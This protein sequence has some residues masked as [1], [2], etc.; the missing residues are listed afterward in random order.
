MTARTL[1]PLGWGLLAALLLLPLVAMQLTEQVHWTRFDFAFAFTMFAILGLGMELISRL[2][3]AL[4][5]RALLAA[6]AL[7]AFLLV[8][9]AFATA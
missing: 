3:L 8:W 9:G 4:R 5:N 7:L 6:G 1:R 2:P